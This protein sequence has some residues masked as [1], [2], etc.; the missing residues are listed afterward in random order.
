MK[1]MTKSKQGG[2][3]TIE[4]ALGFF[5]FW[6]MIAAW[7][8]MSYISYISSIGDLA[9]AQA[10]RQAKKD[11]SNYDTVFQNVINEDDQIWSNLV[12]IS[13]FDMTVEFVDSLTDL[14]TIVTA[15]EPDEDANSCGAPETGSA[16]AIYRIS[17]DYDSVFGYFLDETT[18]FSREVIVVQEYQRDQFQIGAG[19]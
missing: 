18:V 6:L 5:A 14:E 9:I 4:F 12:D 16:I 2:V 1:L 19:T 13:Q 17:Y 15:C 11:T 10:S 7:A 8:E 3:V